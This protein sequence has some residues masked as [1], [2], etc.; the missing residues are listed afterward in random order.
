MELPAPFAC[1]VV[2]SQID[3]TYQGSMGKRPAL[4][5]RTLNECPFDLDT[6]CT[7]I[8][9]TT[10]V[11]LPVTVADLDTCSLTGVADGSLVPGQFAWNASVPS[12]S[13]T[14][15]QSCVGDGFRCSYAAAA[16]FCKCS[17]G[18]DSCIP[19]G[20]CYETSCTICQDCITKANTFVA[21][22]LASR[23]S[24]AIARAW[25]SFCSSQ[26]TRATAADCQLA[27]DAIAASTYGNLGK[28][29]ATLCSWVKC[30]CAIQGKAVMAA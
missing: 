22:Q 8:P 23:D 9:N 5:C 18:V 17:G 25:G 10:A 3:L 15:T 14:A 29:A 2:A 27:N 4:L 26:L 30:E 13:C 19:V 12:S 21:S 28:R 6:T 16:R 20:E 11:Q 7:L 1:S 24:A